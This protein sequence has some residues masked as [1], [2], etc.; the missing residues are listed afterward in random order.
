MATNLKCLAGYHPRNASR[1]GHMTAVVEAFRR[2]RPLIEATEAVADP[3]EV[4]PCVFH[5]QWHDPLT[6]C[7]DTPLH[8]RVLLGTQGWSSPGK[9]GDAG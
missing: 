8:E 2:P 7:L 1:P 4:L 6:A 9:M 5:A 3:I